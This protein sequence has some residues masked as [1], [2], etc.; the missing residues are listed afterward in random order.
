MPASVV[1]VI[2]KIRDR[3]LLPAWVAIFAL[4]IAAT[5]DQTEA[6]WMAREGQA[7]L[8][9]QPLIHPDRWSWDPQP[10]NFIPTSPLWELLSGAFWN[11]GH[12][13]GLATLAL[14]TVVFCLGVLTWIAR[15]L[16]AM[17]TATVIAMIFCACLGSAILTAR[18]GLPAFVLLLLEF[19][20]AWRHRSRWAAAGTRSAAGL[21]TVLTFAVAVVGSWL[22]NSWAAFGFVAIGGLWLLLRNPEF[23]RA[24]HRRTLA[25]SV[26]VGS[27]FGMSAGPLG[28][29]AW[30]NSLRVG[31]EC[32]G[33]I[34]EWTSPWQLGGFWTAM[35]FL[36]AALVTAL[37]VSAVRTEGKQWLLGLEAPFLIVAIGGIAA[38]AIAIRFMLL[39]IF[40]AM[41]SLALRLSRGMTSTATLRFRRAIGERAHEPYWRNL[42]ALLAVVALP[43]FGAQAVLTPRGPDAAVAAL[44]ANCNMFADDWITKTVELWR[45]DVKVWVDGRQDY[46]GR[47]RLLE[48][49]RYMA[50]SAPGRLVPPGTSCVLLYS[51]AKSPLSQAI[52]KNT[53]WEQVVRT[54][55]LTAWAR[56]K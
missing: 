1:R 24:R 54:P 31:R 39:G 5:G 50:A 56:I 51:P 3:G 35:W 20:V 8:R 37:L 10:W 29:N 49:D 30:S 41:P 14:A 47:A 42:A 22:H 27:L 17:P 6:M 34:T 45:P 25:A 16:G 46:W 48:G 18:A 33:L 23:G 21:A 53:A 11:V 36:S 55:T 13:L 52:A 4:W 43:L 2:C 7:L 28:L 44:P 32:R 40:A 15:S 12:E 38:G 19:V 9:G 26:A